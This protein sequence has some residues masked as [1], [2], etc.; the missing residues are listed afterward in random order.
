LEQKK[1]GVAHGN[2]NQM[3]M[4]MQMQMQ[5]SNDRSFAESRRTCLRQFAAAAA[6]SCRRASSPRAPLVCPA[7]ARALHRIQINDKLPIR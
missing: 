1:I 7:S 4:Q 3:Q 5:S 6:D 2:F